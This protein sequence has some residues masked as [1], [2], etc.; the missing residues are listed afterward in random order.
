MYLIVSQAFFLF[1]SSHLE[2]INWNIAR[3]KAYIE[4]QNIIITI[5]ASTVCITLVSGE[6]HNSVIFSI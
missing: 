3:M 2:K 4:P 1:A 6:D 5:I